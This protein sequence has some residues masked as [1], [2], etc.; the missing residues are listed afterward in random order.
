MTAMPTRRSSRMIQ[1]ARPVLASAATLALLGGCVSLGGKAPPQLLTLTSDAAPTAGS[2]SSASVTEAIIVDV[3]TVER[4][5]DQ[6]R[7]PVQVSDS[8]IAYV[9]DAVWADKPARLFR[10]VLAETLAAKSGRLVL[11]QV[12]TGS[13]RGMMLSGQ[14]QRFGYDEAARAVVVRYDAVIR[15]PGSPLRK[16]RFEASEPVATVDAV[17]VGSALNRAANTVAGEVAAWAVN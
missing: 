17:S 10:G 2:I 8:A 15:K 4:T 5:L 9:E 11:D 12:E 13:E 16:Q 3:P 14:L 7:V 1:M 6:V